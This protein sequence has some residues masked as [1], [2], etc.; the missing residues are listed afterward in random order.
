MDG[1]DARAAE[2]MVAVL[3]RFLPGVPRPFVLLFYHDSRVSALE[4]EMTAL[5]VS[6]IS[7]IVVEC[8]C[9]Q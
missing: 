4:S 5:S 2:R 8:C 9:A 1:G 3:C 7:S 6:L